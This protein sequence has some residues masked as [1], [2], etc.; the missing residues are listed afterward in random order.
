MEVECFRPETYLFRKHPVDFVAKCV[1]CKICLVLIV[2][3]ILEVNQC[4]TSSRSQFL[5]DS[6][7]R[8]QKQ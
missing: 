4:F 2:T 1:E 5:G 6:T 7:V 3:L 8:V